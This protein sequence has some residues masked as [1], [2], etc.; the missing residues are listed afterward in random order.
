LS[1]TPTLA[2]IHALA[3]LSGFPNEKLLAVPPV[4]FVPLMVITPEEVT[5]QLSEIAI[6]TSFTP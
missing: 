2:K 6:T 1:G 3:G 5:A 4:E